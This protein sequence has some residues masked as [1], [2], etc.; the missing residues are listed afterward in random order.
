MFPHQNSVSFRVVNTCSLKRI[1]SCSSIDSIVET[2]TISGNTCILW[3]E[4]VLNIRVS[5]LNL[6]LQTLF[7]H[8]N[9]VHYCLHT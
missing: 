8:K 6:E 9:S 2:F 4:H 3:K 1:I 7:R 5:T